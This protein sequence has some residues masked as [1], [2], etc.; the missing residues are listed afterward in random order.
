MSTDEAFYPGS[1]TPKRSAGGT[2]PVIPDSEPQEWEQM[3]MTVLFSGK[4]VTL[5]PI[6]ALASA[7]RRDVKTVRHWDEYKILPP[8]QNR[9]ASVSHHGRW[10]LYTHEQ[11]AGLQRIAESEGLFSGKRVYVR[12][13]NFVPRAYQLF[14]DLEAGK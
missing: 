7:L 8:A 12:K 9:T 13:T 2:G 11:I 14:V 5:Y 1:N 3:G 10:R 4:K 6:S